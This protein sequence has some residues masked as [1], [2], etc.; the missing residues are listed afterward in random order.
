[1]ETDEEYGKRI[2]NNAFTYSIVSFLGGLLV[3]FVGAIIYP[4][5]MDNYLIWIPVIGGYF[6][7]RWLL[8]PFF[9]MKITGDKRES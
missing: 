5:F 2:R 4:P 1:M 9:V 8:Q 3:L 7:L 6:L